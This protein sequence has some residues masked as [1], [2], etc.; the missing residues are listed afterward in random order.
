[1]VYNVFKIASDDNSTLSEFDLITTY[2]EQ[3]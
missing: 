1:M 3:R 2:E